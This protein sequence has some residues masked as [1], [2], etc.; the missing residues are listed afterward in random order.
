MSGLGG[1]VGE[2]K[3]LLGMIKETRDDLAGYRGEK[4]RKK[5]E[6]D[7]KKERLSALI[8]QRATWRRYAD[9]NSDRVGNVDNERSLKRKKPNVSSGPLSLEN[10]ASSFAAAIE[11]GGIRRLA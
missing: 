9:G 5:V 6:L 4:K 3:E 11:R 7:E 8:R 1:E 2:L 10:E